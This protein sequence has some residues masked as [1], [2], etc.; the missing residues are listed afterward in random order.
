MMQFFG[1]DDAEAT[2]LQA[3]QSG[4]FHHAWLLDGPKGVGKNSFAMRVAGHLL[5]QSGNID[6]PFTGFTTDHTDAGAAML[7]NRNHPDCHYI[8]RGPK[9]DKEAR[10]KEDGKAFEIGRNIKVNQIRALQRRMNVRPSLSERRVIII[11]SAD[12]M[13][14]GAANALLKSLEEPPEN[15]TF[16]L[17]SHHPGKLLPTIRSRCLS[18]H[19]SALSDADMEKAL[20]AANPDIKNDEILA[21]TRLGKGVPGEAL[22]MA[23]LDMAA[24]DLLLQQISR[25][26]DH[27][28][29]ARLALGQM[30]S[31]KAHKERFLAFLRYVPS[32]AAF[33]VRHI[34]GDHL[35]DAIAA[36]KDINDIASRSA[37]LNLDP[38]NVAFQ[39]GGLLAR[40]APPR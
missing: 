16:F 2:I 25:S 30:V 23:G 35:P 38:Q 31:G 3:L 10:K 39:I 34:R 17:I 6:P 33:R 15:T 37:I 22:A 12:D 11:D 7:D 4:R 1:H 26:G 29:R 27:D 32:F 8:A 40:L 19:F 24:I 28:Q 21:L 18:L 36:W 9:D 14:K 13:E 5:T 20:R